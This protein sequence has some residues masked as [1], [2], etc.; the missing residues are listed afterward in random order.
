M[1]NSFSRFLCNLI[2]GTETS[3]EDNHRGLVI[4]GDSEAKV[5]EFKS[6]KSGDKSSK[7][8]GKFNQKTDSKNI[9][10]QIEQNNITENTMA[11]SDDN[12]IDEEINK[13]LKDKLKPTNVNI[14]SFYQLLCKQ[15][16]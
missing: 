1:G 9:S 5:V 2:Q 12:N 3:I 16:M 13:L 10:N 11:K 6:P 7:S 4:Y 15:Q 8:M 14:N